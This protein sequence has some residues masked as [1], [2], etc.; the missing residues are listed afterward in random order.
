MYSGYNL[1]QDDGKGISESIKQQRLLEFQA[2]ASQVE[3]RAQEAAV[4]GWK[5]DIYRQALEAK[6][7]REEQ[8]KQNCGKGPP[9]PS[10]SFCIADDKWAGQGLGIPKPHHQHLAEDYTE[11][12]TYRCVCPL[13]PRFGPA[14]GGSCKTYNPPP[15]GE[16][17]VVITSRCR[18]KLFP[19]I[20]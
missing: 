14:F 6:A 7:I 11:E 10:G 13:L 20:L 3:Q 9:C 19:D 12:N 18:T 5:L 15:P 2:E 17:M 16:W 1:A 8:S 4:S